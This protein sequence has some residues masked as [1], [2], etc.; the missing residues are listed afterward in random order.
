MVK[1]ISIGTINKSLLFLMLMSISNVLYTY[2][3]GFTYIECFYPINIYKSLYHWIINK[4]KTDF[5]RH[6][7]FDPLFCYVGVIFLTFFFVKDNDQ[8]KED[9]CE[10]ETTLNIKF[11]V[12]KEKEY[13]KDFKGLSYYILIIV[14][15]VMEENLILIY[16]DIFQDLDFWFFELIFVSIIFSKVFIFK[17]SS[18]QK[19]G[20]SISIIVGSVLKIYSISL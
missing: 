11:F 6:R 4:D 20:M 17:I 8:V 1:L 2:I 13:L 15:W 16:V 10:D 5:P 14:L 3:Y 18:H 7:V 9:N 19:L 12:K